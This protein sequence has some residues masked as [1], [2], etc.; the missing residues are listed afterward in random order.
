VGR[1]ELRVGQEVGWGSECFGLNVGSA[2]GGWDRR[3]D[4]EI[5]W[6]GVWKRE[7][8]GVWGESKGVSQDVG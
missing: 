4:G 6:E 8:W 7:K 2:M 1:Q 3:V 5:Q